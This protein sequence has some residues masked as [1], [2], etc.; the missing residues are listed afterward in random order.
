MAKKHIH[1]YHKI[2][3]AYS[4]LWA[5]ALPD[6]NHYMPK[7][8]ENNVPGKKSICWECGN[9]MILD[10]HNMLND[11]PIC[12]SCDKSTGNVLSALEHFGVK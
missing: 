3:L 4:R 6:C 2:N 12:L 5:C 11:K 8:L 10:D 9:E 1:K 7:H